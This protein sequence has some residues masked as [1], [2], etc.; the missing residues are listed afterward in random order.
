MT[1]PAAHEST[2]GS[3]IVER[4]KLFSALTYVDGLKQ[5]LDR[6]TA[7][8]AELRLKAAADDA[9]MAMLVSDLQVSNAARDRYQDDAS[10]AD[11]LREAFTRLLVSVAHQCEEMNKARNPAYQPNGSGIL[12]PAEEMEMA[13]I[14]KGVADKKAKE[15][16]AK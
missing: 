9:R 16:A 11:A 5:Q 14:V 1:S 3:D 10:R 13:R 12:H 6:A 8:L 4:E 2:I 15:T 7:E